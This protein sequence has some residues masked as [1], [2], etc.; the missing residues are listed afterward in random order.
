MEE[1]GS[2]FEG[3]WK[4]GDR[5][6]GLIEGGGYAQYAVVHGDMVMEVPDEMDF[7]SAAGIPEAFLTS[8]Q[9]LYFYGGLRDKATQ[10]GQTILIHAGASGIGTAAIQ[11]AK[12]HNNKVIVTSSSEDKLALCKKANHNIPKTSN[13]I[14][15]NVFFLNFRTS[16]SERTT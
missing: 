11:L 13:S 12:M 15:L 7:E 3:L 10:S 4:K 8:Y 5:I 1:V 9:L 16:S 2:D 6:C 14:L